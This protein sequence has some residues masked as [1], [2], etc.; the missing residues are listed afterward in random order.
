[1]TYGCPVILDVQDLID[2][3][4]LI[5]APKWKMKDKINHSK[6]QRKVMRLCEEIELLNTS[7]RSESAASVGHRYGINKLCVNVSQISVQ[8]FLPEKGKH[9]IPV[10]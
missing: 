9:L 2:T 5:I 10:L 3:Q 7:A 1:M 6:R 8:A 4:Q